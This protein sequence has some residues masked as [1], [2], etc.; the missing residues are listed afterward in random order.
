MMIFIV[1]WKDIQ[2][3]RYSLHV[4]A[5]FG[6]LK[7][8]GRREQTKMREAILKGE[9][10]H[11]FNGS[12]RNYSSNHLIIVFVTASSINENEQS[13]IIKIYFIHTYTYH[14]L[15]KFVFLH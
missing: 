15:L 9:R 12:N 3:T 6:R 8:F 5:L 10:K 13:N 2:L 4:W 11:M 14:S 7:P 1:Y